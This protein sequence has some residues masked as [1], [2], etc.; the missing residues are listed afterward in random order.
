MGYRDAISHL[1]GATLSSQGLERWFA[2]LV[3]EFSSYGVFA[4]QL[5]IFNLKSCTTGANLHEGNDLI[6]SSHEVSEV[7]SGCLV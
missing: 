1:F 7:G 6:C 3:R 5:I 4:H 2:V